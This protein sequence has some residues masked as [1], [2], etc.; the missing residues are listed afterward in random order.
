VP[1][2]ISAAKPFIDSV[3]RAKPAIIFFLKSIL[4]VPLSKK[5]YL[6]YILLSGEK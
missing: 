5:K 3:A 6:A 1:A 4:N 2:F